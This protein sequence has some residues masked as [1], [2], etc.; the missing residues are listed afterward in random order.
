LTNEEREI[1]V[2]YCVIISKYERSK[3]HEW[4]GCFMEG[5][6][7]KMLSYPLDSDLTIDECMLAGK[8][9]NMHFVGMMN[10]N[11]CHGT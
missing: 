3:K 4:V 9:R 1:Y 7:Q 6:P 8:D 2:D 5:D 10:G 11:E